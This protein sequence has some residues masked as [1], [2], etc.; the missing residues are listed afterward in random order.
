MS[1][2]PQLII[3]IATYNERATLP[4]LVEGIWQEIP[5]AHIL[6]VDDN[7]PDGTGKWVSEQQ[8]ER[9]ELL[10]R[11]TKQGLGVATIAGLQHAL[12]R[13]PQ[14]IATM[15][16]DL[17]HSP[18]DLGKMWRAVTEDADSCDVL[19]GS[20]YVRGGS[21][22]N[23][24][25]SRRAT[26]RA[27]NVFA[28]WVLWLRPRDNT[29]AFRLYR[30]TSLRQIDLGQI[31]CPGYAYLEQIL[32]HLQASGARLREHPIRFSDRRE[33]QSKVNAGELARNARDILS[34]AVRRVR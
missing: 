6:I 29:S 2:T 33:G 14:W 3:V 1:T 20:R 34:L 12:A 25:L 30:A 4:S 13:S 22:H 32:I 31:D 23:W 7:S 9:L 18:T 24:S 16:A 27:V 21:I 10:H 19:I 8:D 11:E 26:S 15:D 17:S 5:R 28:R